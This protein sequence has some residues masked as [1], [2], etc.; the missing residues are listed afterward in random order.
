[1]QPIPVAE[2]AVT[3]NG[4]H[5]TFM[6]KVYNWMTMG[7]AITALVALGIEF[8]F[9]GIK[10][11]IL[12]NVYIF[13]GLLVAELVLV[14]ILSALINKIP[15]I[16]ALFIFFAYA[17][18][19]GVTFGVL[20]TFFSLRSIT[21]SFFVTAAM[22]GS[23]SVIGYITK[24]DLSRFGGFLTMLLIGL[25]LASIANVFFHSS[26]FESI[27]C[28]AGVVIFVGLTIW[29]TQK[30]KKWSIGIDESSE[31]GTK[32]SI[33]GALMLYLDFINMFLFVLRLF[34]END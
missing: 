34:G 19:N 20:F 2:N 9:P 29:D 25:I 28:Y 16:L 23:T 30:I 6:L 8:A 22:F 11:F 27:V 10:T 32:A 17:A 24:K 33:S 4:V 21:Y 26:M 7:L 1:L 18:F 5:V 14:G 15:T 31:E 12:H 3:E 13:Y